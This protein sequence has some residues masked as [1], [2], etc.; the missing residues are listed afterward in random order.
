MKKISVDIIEVREDFPNRD[1]AYAL[2]TDGKR[3]AFAWG[4]VYP[5]AEEVPAENVPAGESGI[6]WFDTEEEAR[7]AMNEASAAWSDAAGN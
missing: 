1:E 3:F 4:H 2:L 7:S 5:H 6:E